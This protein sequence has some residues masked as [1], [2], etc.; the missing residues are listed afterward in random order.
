ML[1]YVQYYK[2]TD[3][4]LG[5][6]DVQAGNI[7]GLGGEGRK[8]VVCVTAWNWSYDFFRS[9]IPYQSQPDIARS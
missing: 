6:A 5:M 2:A 1:A 7:V 9:T 8:E 4:S 3:H